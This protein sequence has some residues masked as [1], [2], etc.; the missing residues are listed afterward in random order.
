MTKSSLLSKV[1]QA[2]IPGY[3][4]REILID[5]SIRLM[6]IFTL[7]FIFTAFQLWAPQILFPQVPFVWVFHDAPEIIEWACLAGAIFGSFIW[8]F[9]SKKTPF[10]KSLHW[11]YPISMFLLVMIDQHRFQA[12]LAQFLIFFFIAFL[13]P[14]KHKLT[15]MRI[16]V[17][18]IYF[19]SAISKFDIVFAEGLGTQFA[20]TL[21]SFVGVQKGS[22]TENTYSL[23]AL[24]L[25]TGELIVGVLLL[26]PTLRWIGLPA[27]VLMH[28]CMLLV[29]GP[30]GLNHNHGV[31]IWN[32]YFILQNAILFSS[33]KT[34]EQ[35]VDE[36]AKQD[37]VMLSHDGKII[38]IQERKT[39]GRIITCLLTI[40][41]MMPLLEPWG[42]C[43]QW[44]AWKLYAPAGERLTILVHD[45]K[46]EIM[47][48]R[49]GSSLVDSQIPNWKIVRI[50]RWSLLF[51]KTPIYPQN[52]FKL[53]I[54]IALA[55]RYQLD[56]EIQV[57]VFSDANRWSGEREKTELK[58]IKEINQHAR[59]YWLN[60]FPSANL[61]RNAF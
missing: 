3:G 58:G 32:T 14:Q 34:R 13:A 54:A 2:M 29:L 20:Q 56:H 17:I 33:R 49:L 47:E 61:H 37:N 18:A 38:H 36:I 7:L 41:L 51:L 55:E 35:P 45:S 16:F 11:I 31:L 52:R 50:D 25:P 60:A 21:L 22:L 42:F 44:L 59:K 5:L 10:S 30:Y 46:S 4:Q 28:A 39:F 26:F 53:G 15:W 9:R 1:W 19:Y 6:G 23:I 24:M 27:A 40:I 8:I 48:P 57:L 12:W 43:D